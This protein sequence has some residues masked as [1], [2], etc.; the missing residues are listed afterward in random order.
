MYFLTTIFGLTYHDLGL[1]HPVLP[2]RLLNYL[3]LLVVQ[4]YYTALAVWIGLN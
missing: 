4:L 2:S 3:L 1:F